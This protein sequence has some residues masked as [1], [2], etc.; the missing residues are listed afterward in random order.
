MNIL[1]PLLALL[2]ATIGLS[3]LLWL[4]WT[5]PV[6]AHEWYDAT[7]CS[8]RDCAQVP[9][10]AVGFDAEGNYLITLEPGSHPLV[11]RAQ[12]WTFPPARARASRDGAWHACVSASADAL[13][14]RR[15]LCVYEPRT[16]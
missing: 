13:G 7:C 14:N 3:A 8:G 12:T 1:R 5:L 11:T 10:D 6:E 9:V 15:L 2:A 16:F 4:V